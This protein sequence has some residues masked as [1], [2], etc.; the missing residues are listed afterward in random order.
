MSA[1]KFLQDL[2]KKLWTAAD[3]LRSTLDAAQYKHAV[4]GLLFV[5]YVSDAFDIRRQE[6]SAQFKDPAH[7]YF[8]DPG[9]FASAAEYEA[10]I[11]AELEIRDYYTEKNVFWV[12]ALG[13]WENL[14]NNS[15]LPAGTKI[16]IKNGKTMTY[17]IRSVGRLIDDALDAIEKDNPKLKGVLN[18][19]YARLQID[20][21]KLGELIDL[22]AT[23]PFVHASLQAKDI[24][25]HVYEY[26]LGQFA[27]AEGKKGGQFYT[28][29]S[30]VTLIVEMLQPYQGRVYDP[31]M[32]SGGFFVQSERFI[33]E[34]G[35]KLG[36]VSIYGQEYNH[37]TWQLAAMNM[38]I[39]GLDF[40][41]GK[42][43]ANTFTNDQHPDLR[44]NY[45]MA[46]P[47]FNM[48]E[49]DTGVKDDDP[50]WQYGRPPT[51]NANF[52]WL[53]HMIYHLAPEGIAGIVLAN[54]SLASN[55]RQEEKVREALIASNLIDCIVTLPDKLFTSTPIG[56]CIWVL[57]KGRSKR[58]KKRNEILFIDA[59]SCYEHV[60][61]TLNH[62]AEDAIHKI[63]QTYRK[64]VSDNKYSDKPG[65]CK[66][67]HVDSVKT[68]GNSLFPAAYIDIDPSTISSLSNQML[69]QKIDKINEVTKRISRYGTK[70]TEY[71]RELALKLETKEFGRFKFT[72]ND[73]LERSNERLGGRAEPEIL[74]CTEGAGLVLQRERFAKRVATEDTSDYKIVKRAN[75]VY[76]PYLLWAGS[77][78]QCWIVEEG[79][80]SPAYEVFKI[81]DGFD[82][83]LVGVVLKSEEMMKKY[84]GISIGTV[85]RRRRAPPE[86]FLDLEIFL[87]SLEEQAEITEKSK[88]LQDCVASHMYLS[89]LYKEGI[90]NI[91]SCIGR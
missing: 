80:T 91:F 75:I 79:I 23:I 31:A 53:Q 64:W 72:L 44:A 54:M 65:F 74:T 10:E 30:I 12:P 56:A 21:A 52:A 78:D 4:L 34:H 41:F 20:Q 6:L 48:K 15:K 40:N 82:P 89:R 90:V 59:T 27:L 50:R 62:L 1:E 17:E 46:N 26:F 84:D 51:G 42:E 7:E 39:R 45:V 88:D 11:L 69:I 8:L 36:N 22:I 73:I 14:Q 86:K 47:P 3:K 9:D 70:G 18:K 5:K 83:L 58:G 24:L 25:G 57:N 32:G 63:S 81:R 43:P 33:K 85:K 37:T 49:W 87:P 61:R 19:Q 38:V 55:D 13:R 77:I 68:N 2:E 60:S 67:I 28:P 35:G 66:S 29:K 71:L 16:E 76:N